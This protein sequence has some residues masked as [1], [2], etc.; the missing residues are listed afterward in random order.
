MCARGVY[1]GELEEDSLIRFSS[2]L[3]AQLELSGQEILESLVI[4]GDV[5]TS[6]NT[7][8]NIIDGN[9]PA[10]AYY[11]LFDGFRRLALVGNAANSLSAAGTLEIEDFIKIMKL[12]GTAGLAGS[13]PSTLNF[14][15]DGNTYYAMAQL[16]EVKTKDINTA[17][18]VENGFVQKLWGVGVLPSW[19]M[20]RAGSAKRMANSAGKCTTTDSGNTLGAALCVRWDQWKLAYKRRMTMEVTRIANADSW[21]IVALCRLGLGYRDTEAASILYNIGL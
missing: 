7:N 21:E 13:D 17:A 8:I 20:H 14:I 12:M 10:T 2:Q 4:D 9:A 18:T 1:T 16:A 5:D 3:R 11:T 15:C 6:T 19:Q